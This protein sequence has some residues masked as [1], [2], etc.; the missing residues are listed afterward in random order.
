MKRIILVLAAAAVLAVPGVANADGNG[1]GNG[2]GHKGD[3]GQARCHLV[4]NIDDIHITL[5]FKNPGEGF[6]VARALGLNPN[7]VAE[8]LGFDSVGEL[9]Q[10]ICANGDDDDDNNGDNNGD[11]GDRCHLVVGPNTTLHFKNPA[12]LFKAGREFGNPKELAAFLQFDSVGELI[13]SAC[14]DDDEESNDD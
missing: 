1:N 2:N 12:A 5:D 7:Q 4:I 14:G 6:R 13:R 9:I 3:N 8:L 10:E 11:N